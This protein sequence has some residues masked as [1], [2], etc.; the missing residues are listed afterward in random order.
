MRRLRQEQAAG[1]TALRGIWG[2]QGDHAPHGERLWTMRRRVPVLTVAVDT[3]EKAGR[4]LEVVDEVTA[5][6]GLVTSETVPAY[7]ATGPGLREGG[8]RM[9]DAYRR[10]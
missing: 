1:A 10:A 7:R 8:L 2:F 5:D 3:P 6:A 9:A 4:L